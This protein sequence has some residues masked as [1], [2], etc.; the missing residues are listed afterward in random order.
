MHILK[1]LSAIVLVAALLLTGCS[2]GGTSSAQKVRLR[3]NR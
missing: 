1:K 2:A 3:C